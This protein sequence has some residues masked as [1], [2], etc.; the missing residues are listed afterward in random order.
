MGGCNVQLNDTAVNG[1]A[2]SEDTVLVY[3]QSSAAELLTE[4][5]D[6]ASHAAG[7]E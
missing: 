3:A 4:P 6:P 5:K 2:K 1:N 7:R